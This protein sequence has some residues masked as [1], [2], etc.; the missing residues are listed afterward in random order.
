MNDSWRA[1]SS[2]GAAS[3][4]EAGSTEVV[5]EPDSSVEIASVTFAFRRARS[6]ACRWRP[7]ARPSGERPYARLASRCFARLRDPAQGAHFAASEAQP[8]QNTLIIAQ[9]VQ[10]PNRPSTC[11][12]PSQGGLDAAGVRRH[13][14]PRR[15]RSQTCLPRRLG[16]SDPSLHLL[17]RA[18]STSSPPSRATTMRKDQVPGTSS[19][20]RGTKRAPTR[21]SVERRGK[22]DACSLRW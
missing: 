8:A 19:K 18:H 4:M 11:Q 12:P 22:P 21:S 15:A 14:A 20:S 16:C 2:G 10:R 9:P 1:G 13:R 5:D 3:V 7:E 6:L 17:Q